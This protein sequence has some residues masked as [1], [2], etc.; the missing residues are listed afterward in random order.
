[1]ELSSQVIDKQ[2]KRTK[3]SAIKRNYNSFEK[4]HEIIAKNFKGKR[5]AKD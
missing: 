4:E 1:M 3:K 5:C 2:G